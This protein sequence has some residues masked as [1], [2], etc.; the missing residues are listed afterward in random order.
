MVVYSFRAKPDDD[1]NILD[2]EES[3]AVGL[4]QHLPDRLGTLVRWRDRN[5]DIEGV[6]REVGHDVIHVLASPRFH[7]T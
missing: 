6:G 1:G 4:L 2:A 3:L 5:I 7:Y